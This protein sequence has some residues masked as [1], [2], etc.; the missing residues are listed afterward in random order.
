MTA[1][2]TFT[3]KADEILADIR[4]D[5]AKWLETRYLTE[6]EK[7]PTA[8]VVAEYAFEPE[9][10]WNTAYLNFMISSGRPL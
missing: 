8:T 10:G 4:D 7:N 3:E 1:M 6:K 2:P 9:E 5:L